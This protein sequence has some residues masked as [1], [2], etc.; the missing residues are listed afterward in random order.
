MWSP[1]RSSHWTIDAWY[2]SSLTDRP[3]TFTNGI[4]RGPGV[5]DMK[6]GIIQLLAALELTPHRDHI[7]VLLTY[8]EETGST[9]S[10]TL[11]EAEARR[12]QA[13]LVCEP[14]ADGGAVKTTRKG[15]ATHRTTATGRAAHA[16]LEPD[17]GINATTE[18]AHQ[19]LA[20]AQLTDPDAGTTVTPTLVHGGVTPNTIPE[21]AEALFDVRAW[22]EAELDRVDTA[23]RSATPHLTG[24]TTTVSEGINRY[25]L[26]PHPGL[27]LLTLVQDAARNRTASCPLTWPRI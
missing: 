4:A 2:A 12:A 16:G 17:L 25:P 9:T 10:R 3:F 21:H 26:E 20:L 8:D 27:D 5:F 23:L 1:S 22:T 15:T 6:A 18:I 11:I 24:A 14:S 19:I 7:S 13:V